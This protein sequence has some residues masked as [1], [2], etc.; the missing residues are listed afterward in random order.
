MAQKAAKSLAVRNKQ[1][2]DQTRLFTIAVHLFYIIFR[3]LIFRNSFTRGS[4]TRYILF[5]LPALSIQFWFE[6]IG[7]PVYGSEPGDLRKSGEDLEA[8]GLT[9]WMWDVLYWTYGC[10]LFA[11]VIGDRAWWLYI[12]VPAYSAYLAY[13]TFTGVRQGMAGLAGPASAEEGTTTQSK[14]QAKLEKRGGQRTQY[15]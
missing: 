6:R 8:K 4:L 13:T 11:A 3:V 2:L 5:S 14:R 10:I 9:E 15:R 12:T 1:K 7:R